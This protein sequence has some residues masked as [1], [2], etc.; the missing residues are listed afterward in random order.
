M[1]A[2]LAILTTIFIF[3]CIDN[4]KI[5]SGVLKQ[6]Q[7]RSVMWDLIRADEFISNYIAK[8]TTKDRKAESFKL[9]ERIF[10]LH[11]TTQEEVRKSLS[12]YQSRPDLLKTVADSL[13]IDEKNAT[14]IQY[15]RTSP[16]SDTS[17]QKLLK[18]N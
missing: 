13:R 14:E 9:Y 10:A 5:P 7:M 15:N 1:R 6:Q 8:D 4:N 11:K 18:R 12:F 17:Q 16:A 2:H 3:A